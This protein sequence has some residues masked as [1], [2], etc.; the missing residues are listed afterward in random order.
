MTL[1][2]WQEASQK[3]PRLKALLPELRRNPDMP[4]FEVDHDHFN[5][6]KN[7]KKFYVAASLLSQNI[8]H[9]EIP[10]QYR[11]QFIRNSHVDLS[12]RIQ[13]FDEIHLWNR[14]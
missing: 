6:G 13:T 9:K 8:T 4:V 11:G 3:N 1:I 12:K 7:T 5:Q 14:I 2:E 10:D